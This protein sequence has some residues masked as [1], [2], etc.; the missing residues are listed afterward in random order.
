MAA[1]LKLTYKP[2][3]G[4]AKS[5]T[6][7]EGVRTVV[8]AVPTGPIF[9]ADLKAGVLTIGQVAPVVT[10]TPTAAKAYAAKLQAVT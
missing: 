3:V 8:K 2:L 4:A 6:V 9:T 7:K 10:M 5:F 1:T